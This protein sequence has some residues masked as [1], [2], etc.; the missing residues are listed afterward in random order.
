MNYDMGELVNYNAQAP[1]GIPTGTYQLKSRNDWPNWYIQLTWHAKLRDVWDI[2]DPDA[3]NAPGMHDGAPQLPLMSSVHDHGAAEQH[4][5]SST[6]DDRPPARSTRSQSTQPIDNST[7]HGTTT[8][9]SID[10]YNQ[11]LARY[12]VRAS[13]W[14]AK[15]ERLQKLWN[16]VNATVSPAIISPVMVQLVT[17]HNTTLQSLVRALRQELAPTLLSTKNQVRSEYRAH[18]GAAKQGR[19]A[20]QDWYQKW[21]YLYMRAKSYELAEVDGELAVQD[22]LDALS[23]RI[24]P[25]WA[26]TMHQRII[27]DSILG[28]Q[29]LTLDQ[30][31]RVFSGLMHE[32]TVRS[33]KDNPGVFATFGNQSDAIQSAPA[34]HSSSSSSTRGYRCPCKNRNYTHKW[35]PTEC[36]AL[37]TAVR[38]L[39]T[40]PY[41]LSE[42]R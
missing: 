16:W 36:Q 5:A 14:S 13:E 15:A 3:P 40:P 22:F 23:H 18:L 8:P 7:P 12:K 2:V 6:I 25:E 30:V 19:V 4:F 29:T 10:A 28:L 11:E 37:E 39:S 20:P 26:R 38:G 27:Q 41:T 31:S 33:G 1:Y 35:K 17:T 34:G 24:A 42:Q 32:H 9:S 21:S